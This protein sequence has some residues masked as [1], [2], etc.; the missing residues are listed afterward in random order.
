MQDI[1]YSIVGNSPYFIHNNIDT[2]YKKEKEV[3]G[4]IPYTKNNTSDCIICN[5]RHDKLL[6]SIK[7]GTR[8]DDGLKYIITPNDIK[9]IQ[10]S[11]KKEEASAQLG[12]VTKIVKGLYNIDDIKNIHHLFTNE[13]FFKKIKS[14]YQK[15]KS[16]ISSFISNIYNKFTK[17]NQ[18]YV[19]EFE[20]AM[21]LNES[22][23]NE[24][25]VNLINEV[26]SNPNKATSIVN[27][28]LNKIVSICQNKG[29]PI[30]YKKNMNFE[31][32][33]NSHV[34]KIIGNFLTLKTILE[35]I[36]DES[37]IK[38]NLNKIVGEMYFGGTKL[39]LWKV[40]G[41]FGKKSYSYMGTLDAFVNKNINENIDIFGIRINDNKNAYTITLYILEDI[42]ENNKYYVEL[43]TGTNS[44]SKIT[45][46]VEGTKKH[47]PFEINKKLIE[48]M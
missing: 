10:V 12:K 2:Y 29:I 7:E 17:I 9:Y 31:I 18:K 41:Y 42:K 43:R 32:K 36:L 8:A 4:E 13:S 5:E 21:G 11:L 48:I 39:P 24:N 20:K 16:I 3:F 30:K 25:N 6:S 15:A 47:G 44:S 34:F 22:S 23:L 1:G 35:I 40:F 38:T 46:I 27:N 37:Q 19:S 26:L 33:N 45:F 28:E 14:I